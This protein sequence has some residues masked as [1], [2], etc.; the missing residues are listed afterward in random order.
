MQP[1]LDS[2][3]GHEDCS[4]ATSTT[5]VDFGGERGSSLDNTRTELTAST[6]DLA[7]AAQP[8]NERGKRHVRSTEKIEIVVRA[9]IDPAN[10][11]PSSASSTDT[12]SVW[13]SPTTPVESSDHVASTVS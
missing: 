6:V 10:S 5:A 12:V 8:C 9:T 3:V 13:S 7:H 1:D 4:P 11:A 2:M